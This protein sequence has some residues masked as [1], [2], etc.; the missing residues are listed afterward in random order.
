MATEHIKDGAE[1]YKAGCISSRANPFIRLQGSQDEKGRSRGI[2]IAS[3]EE[4]E[5]NSR[6]HVHCNMPR[7]LNQVRCVSVANVEDRAR[8]NGAERTDTGNACTSRQRNAVP[9]HSEQIL[10]GTKKTNEQEKQH[11][12]S[13]N[14][15]TMSCM[16]SY[17]GKREHSCKSANACLAVAQQ[18][19]GTNRNGERRETERVL[20]ML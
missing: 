11:V 10:S 7:Q 12:C 17:A 18:V 20:E 5:A 19:I 2:C 3:G 4:Q 13:T 15:W 8:L 14:S 6:Q 16:V 9:T 1:A